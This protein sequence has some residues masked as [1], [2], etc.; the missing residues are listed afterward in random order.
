[1]LATAVVAADLDTGLDF[2]HPDV[3]PNYDPKHSADCSGGGAGPA[4]ARQ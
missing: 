2:T 4:R 3:A 1:V